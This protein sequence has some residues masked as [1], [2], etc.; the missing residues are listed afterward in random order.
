MNSNHKIKTVALAILLLP[1]TSCSYTFKTY[2]FIKDGN[3]FFDLK[4]DDL[5]FWNKPN[6]IQ[7]ITVEIKDRTPI[8][9]TAPDGSTLKTYPVNIQWEYKGMNSECILSFPLQYG[10]AP[11]K[12]YVNTPAKKLQK[13]VT[14]QVSILSSGSGYGAI[15]FL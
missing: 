11:D 12:E 13:D 5:S 14:Y 15:S 8:E 10:I 1:L 7:H 9:I 6:C 3:L 2:S 4:T